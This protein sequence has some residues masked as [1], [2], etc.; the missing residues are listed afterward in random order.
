VIGLGS[1]DRGDDAVGPV[2][3]RVVAA[4]GVSGVTVIEH[5]DPTGLIDTWSGTGLTVVIDAVRTGA[6]P[7][8]LVV[9]EAGA[10]ADPLV[11]D[12]WVSAGRGGTHAFGLAA[13]VELARALGKLPE[14]LVLVGV[15]AAG[16]EHGAEMSAPVLAA[17]DDVVATVLALIDGREAV[18]GPGSVSVPEVVERPEVVGADVSG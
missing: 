17:L 2:A 10:D 5:E 11:D 1:P 13:A 8:T 14:R 6:P 16:F 7:G 15:E 18:D 12:A 4:L 3:A 9:L